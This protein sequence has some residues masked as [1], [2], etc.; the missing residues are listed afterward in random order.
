MKGK[1][2]IIIISFTL[3]FIL[4]SCEEVY[5]PKKR[6]YYRFNLPEKSYVDWTAKNKFTI[7]IPKY[8]YIDTSRADSGWYI[9]KIPKLK[10]TLYLT[11]RVNPDLGKEEEESRSL[12]YKHA[13]K[14]DDIISQDYINDTN[15][16]YATVFDIKG[17]TASSI[18]FHI[19]DSTNRFFRG[20]LYFYAKPNKDSLAPAIDFVRKDIVHLI[21]NFKWQNDK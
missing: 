4:Y 11:Y 18:N 10:A 19:V 21:E 1:I 9:M 15:K 13:I 12:V 20:A 3:T 7:S 14:A 5:T 16:V 17:N 8:S 2:K 6:G